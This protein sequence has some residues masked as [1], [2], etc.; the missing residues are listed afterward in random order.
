MALKTR[1]IPTLL[2]KDYSLV[3]GEKFDSWRRIGSLLPAIKVYNQRDVDELILLDI[4]ATS[5]NEVDFNTLADIAKYCRVPLTYGGG[6]NSLELA[7]KAFDTGIDKI[8]INSASYYNPGIIRQV[9]DCFG[10]QSIVASIDAKRAGDSYWECYSNSGTK[11]QLISVVE[12][13][14]ELEGLGAGEIIITSIDRD[15][16]LGGY[17]IDMIANVSQSVSV[18]VIASGG[19]MSYKDME[20]AILI[21]GASAIAA[22]SIFQFTQSTPLEA[23]DFL[24][25]NGIPVRKGIL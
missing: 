16:T 18:P 7:E 10:S 12:K 2:W 13:A 23:K 11:K 15:G 24:E 22:S 19:C 1:I 9:A 17:D 4:A 21:G 3:K 6:I 8:S 5:S 20:D 14:K 25:K